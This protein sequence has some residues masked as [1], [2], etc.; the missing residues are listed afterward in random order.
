[1]KTISNWPKYAL[2]AFL[3]IFGD[4]KIFK[5]PMFIVY[6]PRGYQVK[7]DD[8]RE[9]INLAQPGDILVRGFGKYLDGLFIPGYFSHTG[10]YLGEVLPEHVKFVESGKGKALFRSGEQIVAHA[11]A[12]GVFMEDLINFCRCDRML[13]LR[14]PDE[15]SVDLNP[16]LPDIPTE[17]FTDDEL[18]IFN[19]LAQ[20]DSLRFEAVFQ[21]IFKVAFQ[22]IG[23]AYDFQFNFSNYN[24]LS[25]TEF[26]DFCIKS[27]ELFHEMRPA[28]KRYLLFDKELLAPDAFVQSKL[29]L[30][31]QSKSVDQKRI[32]RLRNE[33]NSS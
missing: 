11:M 27:L 24:D 28:K 12:E 6:D 30:V 26:V 4:I 5:W 16:P 10:L 14:F 33:G 17:H 1:M 7:G 9:V 13:I 2:N 31:W 8:V 22:Q 19:A 25:C 15:I 32:D 23:K 20:G 18:K 3:K 21:T 29:E